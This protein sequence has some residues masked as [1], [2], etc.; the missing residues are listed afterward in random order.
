MHSIRTSSNVSSS[1]DFESSI[2]SSR[3]NYI[4]CKGYI[5]NVENVKNHG[6]GWYIRSVTCSSLRIKNHI[7]SV[8]FYQWHDHTITSMIEFN[9]LFI[10]TL[11]DLKTNS[12]EQKYV[13][14]KCFDFEVIVDLIRNLKL[15]TIKLQHTTSFSCRT[16][17]G[18][19][20]SDLA[21]SGIP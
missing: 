2:Y 6:M 1:S 18:S 9:C 14:T 15:K 4:C 20:S 21:L 3:S 19:S 11:W 7:T 12:T 16:F 10:W 17:V 13:A 8:S 5:T